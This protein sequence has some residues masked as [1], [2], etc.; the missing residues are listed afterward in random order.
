M[1]RI[2]SIR[3][4]LLL[5]L[6]AFPVFLPHPV[7][8][9]MAAAG[10]F[11]LLLILLR[12]KSIGR[13]RWLA[14]LFTSLPF[15]LVAINALLHPTPGALNWMARMHG[16]WVFPA[17]LLLPPVVISPA[18]LRWIGRAFIAGMLLIFFYAILRM[19]T[20]GF[21]Q[22]YDAL[23]DFTYRFR[24]EYNHYTR[25]HPGYASIY[26]VFGIYLLLE[27]WAARTLKPWLAIGLL[28][29]MLG[30][31]GMLMA[32]LPLLALITGLPVWAWMKWGGTISLR[33]KRWIWA[34]T[35]LLMVGM[36]I[37]GG[38]RWKEFLTLRQA[39]FSMAEENTLLVRKGVY[40]CCGE[41]L[42]QHGWTGVG[43]DRLQ[44]EL[45]R[46]Y[47]QFPTNVYSRHSLNTHNQ[48]L[49]YWLSYGIAG[50]LVLLA[51]LLAPLYLAWKKKQHI[52]LVFLWIMLLCFLG[53]NILSR[54]AGLVFFGFFNSLCLAM[55]IQPPSSAVSG[56]KNP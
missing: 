33:R 12:W 35:L 11:S 5:L 10:L 1:Q 40:Q 30:M 2:I 53:E 13:Q 9:I 19:I 49:D 51:L 36:G 46:C 56:E 43:P 44:T 15:F 50:L 26:L 8:Y 22:S 39:D 21:H 7:S 27:E 29:V 6:A 28:V 34:A 55:M 52:Y 54:Q 17:M 38:S 31:A 45:N 18:Q 24:S 16:L 41:L 3:F 23:H 14:F 42:Q 47:Y 37:L 4:Y 32:R 20:G 48:Y 25:L